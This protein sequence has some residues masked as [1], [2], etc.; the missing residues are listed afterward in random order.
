MA[1][2][3]VS[4]SRPIKLRRLLQFNNSTSLGITIPKSFVDKLNIRAGEYMSCEMNSEGTSITLNKCS[5]AMPGLMQERRRT[6]D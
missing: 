2:V 4:N 6:N 3:R 5:V 1:Q